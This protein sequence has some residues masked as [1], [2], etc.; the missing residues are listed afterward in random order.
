MRPE[1]LEIVRGWIAKSKSDLETAQLLIVGENRHLDTGAYHCQQAAEKAL[2]AFL[3]ANGVIPPKTHDLLALLDLSVP[4]DEDLA[5]LRDATAMLNPL[6]IQFR[7][8]GDLFEP[9]FSEAVRALHLA[10]EV[11][12][13]VSTALTRLASEESP[14]QH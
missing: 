1:R 8:P 7:Y 9:A 12:T 3:A 14:P 4:F 11:F 2:K 5:T 10:N 13:F 6:G